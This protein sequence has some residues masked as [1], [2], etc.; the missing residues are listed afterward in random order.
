MLTRLS[1]E[2]LYIVSTFI[3]GG[4]LNML[5]L[6]FYTSI[7]CFSSNCSFQDAKVNFLL[8]ILTTL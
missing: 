3:E 1:F 2:E 7:F 4:Y 5:N 8:N 6:K